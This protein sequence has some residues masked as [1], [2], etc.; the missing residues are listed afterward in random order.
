MGRLLRS[1]QA[2]HVKTDPLETELIEVKRPR[3]VKAQPRLV[4]GHTE[5]VEA[6]SEVVEDQ[7][8][9]V[10]LR[11]EPVR[12]SQPEL[13]EAR[14][15]PVETGPELLKARPEPTSVPLTVQPAASMRVPVTQRRAVP[16]DQPA[17]TLV[18]QPVPATEPDVP[19]STQA[20]A[21]SA[22][23]QTVLAASSPDPAPP[24]RRGAA[25]WRE[26]VIVPAPEPVP[27]EMGSQALAEG[28]VSLRP[29]S[30]RPT[31]AEPEPAPTV[32]VTI[33]RVVVRASPA[34]ERPPSRRV[35][36]PRPLVSLEEYLQGRQGGER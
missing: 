6:Q 12:T 7:T 11:H 5:P 34:A 35:E 17:E 3:S 29:P 19:G 23:T 33:G 10:E 4:P 31:T 22:I 25:G 14:P 8:E 21:T 36:L 9:P 24:N 30:V 18:A 28:K 2:E 16:G 15:K 27:G 26:P 20:R 32:R 1:G 13:L